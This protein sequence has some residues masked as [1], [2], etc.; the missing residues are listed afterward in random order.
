[1]KKVTDEN[2]KSRYRKV[3]INGVQMQLHRYLM[4]LFIGRPLLSDE[5]V[6]HINGNKLDNRIENLQVM[7]VSEHSS[8]ENLGK[9]LSKEHKEKVS[10]S[11][12]GNQRR[13]GVQHTQEIKDII[14]QKSKEAR[15]RK[16]WST[17]KKS[18]Q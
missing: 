11:L 4:E 12:I 2:M 13:L 5:V 7:S 3:R 1:M 18:D 15:K 9:K 16:F 14:G 8:L 10:K 17:R 6:H